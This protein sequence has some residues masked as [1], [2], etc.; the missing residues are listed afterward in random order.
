MKNSILSIQ[1]VQILS[2]NEQKEVSGGTFNDPCSIQEA[3]CGK[4][5]YPKCKLK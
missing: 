2:K 4:P 5:G 1:G 3:C